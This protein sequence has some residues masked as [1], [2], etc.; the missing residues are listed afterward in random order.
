MT[1]F[2]IYLSVTFTIALWLGFMIRR[3]LDTFDWRYRRD[4][5]WTGFCLSLALWPLLLVIKPALILKGKVVL[6]ADNDSALDLTGSRA[7]RM[8]MLD[9]ITRNPPACG[10]EIIYRQGDCL[11]DGQKSISLLFRTADIESHFK[12]KDLPVFSPQEAAALVSLIRN[13]NDT[14]LE[15][16]EIPDSINFENL[17]FEMMANGYGMAECP[18]CATSYP[19]SRLNKSFPPRHPGWN[20]DTYAC[21]EGHNLF[22]RKAIHLLLR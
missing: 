15:A 8:R 20:F 18:L 2:W 19:A 10:S 22:N 11:I 21:P 9:Q 16:T 12:G 1:A 13:R 6:E 3:H 5:I 7:K 4:D 17:A 14:Q